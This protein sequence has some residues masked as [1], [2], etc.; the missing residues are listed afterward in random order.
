MQTARVTERKLCCLDQGYDAG[1]TNPT[2]ATTLH[3]ANEST[4]Q[5]VEWVSREQE[6]GKRRREKRARWLLSKPVESSRCLLCQQSRKSE[7]ITQNFALTFTSRFALHGLQVRLGRTSLPSSFFPL[8]GHLLDEVS[9][10]G[11]G[12]GALVLHQRAIVLLLRF[13]HCH[14]Q[15]TYAKQCKK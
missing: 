11:W 6:N 15:G 8:I 9:V 12:R 10:S 3:W 13:W 2:K 14:S 5:W 1:D 7:R 4:T